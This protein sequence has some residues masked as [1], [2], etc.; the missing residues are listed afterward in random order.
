MELNLREKYALLTNGIFHKFRYFDIYI[1]LNNFDDLIDGKDFAFY[2][3]NQA[4]I[5][6]LENIG[7]YRG[8]N[9]KK[10]DYANGIDFIRSAYEL[11]YK[12]KV[13]ISEIKAVARP[14]RKNKKRKHQG[15][16]TECGHITVPYKLVKILSCIADHTDY[17]E[18]II[19]HKKCK[20]CKT[21][22]CSEKNRDLYCFHYLVYNLLLQF[23]RVRGRFR[24]GAKATNV[25]N[26]F[27]SNRR[28]CK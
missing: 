6:A 2:C 15:E 10:S 16:L 13:S 9:T 24:A 14:N 23:G 22:F 3:K 17:P 4:V 1:P 28:K 7:K 27:L 21:N 5:D 19:P 20:D 18:E 25:Y 12:E 26:T 11:Q 8:A